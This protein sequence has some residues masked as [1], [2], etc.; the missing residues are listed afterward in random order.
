L[1]KRF[2]EE[3]V[4]NEFVK[5]AVESRGKLC[6]IPLQDALGLGSEAR[7]NYPSRPLHNWDW[8]VSAG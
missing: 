4:D 2:S 6:L 3:E 7:M 8:R 1:G 5:L